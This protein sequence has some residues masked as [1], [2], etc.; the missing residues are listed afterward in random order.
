MILKRDIVLN[1][2]WS[3]ENNSDDDPDIIGVIFEFL[4]DGLLP[5]ILFSNLFC[6]NKVFRNSNVLNW[7]YE[8]NRF[9]NPGI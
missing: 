2:F 5:R 9:E 4:S 3:L 1:S 8:L 7:Y 6:E